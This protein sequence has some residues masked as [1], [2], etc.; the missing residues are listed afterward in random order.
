MKRKAPCFT[1]QRLLSLRKGQ[2]MT[3]YTGHLPNDITYCESGRQNARAPAYALQLREI[4]R[5]ADDLV[6]AG[7]IRCAKP[8]QHVRVVMRPARD[9]DDPDRKVPT[10]VVVVEYTA[11]GL[12]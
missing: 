1:I 11:E 4:M 9:A 7:R 8:R 2:Q 5:I 12:R 3:Y 6:E 10:Q